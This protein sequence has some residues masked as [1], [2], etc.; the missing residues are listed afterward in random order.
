MEKEKL[1]E[2]LEHC[3]SIFEQLGLLDNGQ[4]EIEEEDAEMEDNEG[5]TMDDAGDKEEY[6]DPRNRSN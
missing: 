6:D 3:K 4:E 5:P 2:E 1:Q